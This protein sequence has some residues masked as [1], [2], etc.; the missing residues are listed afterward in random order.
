MYKYS[1][2]LR[3]NSNPVFITDYEQVMETYTEHGTDIVYYYEETAGLHVHGILTTDTKVYLNSAKWLHP[4]EGWSLKF[5]LLKST[6]DY[7]RWLLYI[8]KEAHLETNL[9]NK[10]FKLAKEFYDYFT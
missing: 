1:F 4:G 7:K 3:K 2:T 9:I 6:G 10:S 5:E 8:M